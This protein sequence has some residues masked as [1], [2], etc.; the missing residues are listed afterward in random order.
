MSNKIWRHRVA[1]VR[2]MLGEMGIISMESMRVRGRYRHNLFYNGSAAGPA[3]S[4]ASRGGRKGTHSEGTSGVGPGRA[5][6]RAPSR[7]GPCGMIKPAGS[8]ITGRRPAGE[9]AEN[10]ATKGGE[11]S[12]SGQQS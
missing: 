2:A 3:W 4:D 8:P 9:E 5:G 1:S 6:R 11:K 10:G 7:L 12:L